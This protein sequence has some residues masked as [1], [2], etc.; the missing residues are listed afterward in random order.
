MN[1]RD[2]RVT[3]ALARIKS[4]RIIYPGANEWTTF[5]CKNNDRG[6]SRIESL[7][8]LDILAAAPQVKQIA[9][10]THHK[11]IDENVFEELSDAV[12]GKMT[13]IGP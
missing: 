2:N 4:L 13:C 10:L 6:V 8:G 7:R 12:R 11:D 5:G 9:L 3:K 1:S